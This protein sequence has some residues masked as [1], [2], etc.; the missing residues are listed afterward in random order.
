MKALAFIFLA[1]L[2]LLFSCDK[3]KLKEAKWEISNCFV[4]GAVDDTNLIYHPVLMDHGFVKIGS[5]AE[6]DAFADY[7]F[8]V[9]VGDVKLNSASSV[10]AGIDYKSYTLFVFGADYVGHNCGKITKDKINV[11]KSSK[12]IFFDF[13]LAVNVGGSGMQDWM[14]LIF[15]IVPNE[16]ATY[17][18]SGDFTYNEKNLFGT[19]TSDLTW[20]YQ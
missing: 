14:N 8:E 18:P 17:K 7:A 13:K 19:G 1:S 10:L 16:Y 20:Y 4:E 12:E 11:V 15:L 6:L 3:V 2:F 5:L 9:K